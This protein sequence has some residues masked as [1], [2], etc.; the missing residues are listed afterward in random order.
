MLRLILVVVLLVLI[1]VGGVA[2]ALFHFYGWK[3]ALA[4]PIVLLA[5]LWL[6]KIFIGKLIKGFALSLFSMKSRVLRGATMTVHSILPVSKP[7]EP[8][9]EE[10]EDEGE[11][12]D[13]DKDE[14]DASKSASQSETAAEPKE[15]TDDE[16]PEVEE[17]K[18]Y[19]AVDFTITPQDSSQGRVWE[20]GEFIL[21][22]EKIKSLE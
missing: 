22:S 2:A 12:E 10:E 5:L 20:P 13:T 1:F 9:A 15:K 3:G 19:F 4:F 21:T 6:G 11:E 8:E 7:Q 17:P 16:V 18:E 14:T